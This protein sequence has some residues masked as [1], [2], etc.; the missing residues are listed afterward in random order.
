V[1]RASSREPAICAGI[2]KEYWKQKGDKEGWLSRYDIAQL[3]ALLLWCIE[4][5]HLEQASP[6]GQC[7]REVKLIGWAGV[8]VGHETQLY[9]EIKRRDRDIGKAVANEFGRFETT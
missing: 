9:K 3:Q 8:T 7:R 1:V 2:V 4:S 6:F 5:C